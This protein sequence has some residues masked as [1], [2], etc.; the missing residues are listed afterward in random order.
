M[1]GLFKGKELKTAENSEQPC[2]PNLSPIG[3]KEEAA[4]LVL[5]SSFRS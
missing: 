4:H 5:G 3:L 1:S 2:L